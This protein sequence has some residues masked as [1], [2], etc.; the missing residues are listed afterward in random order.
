LFQFVLGHGQQQKGIR[1]DILT[2]RLV[3][4]V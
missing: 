4:F 2:D 1:L 3:I